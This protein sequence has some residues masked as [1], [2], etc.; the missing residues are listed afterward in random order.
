MESSSQNSNNILHSRFGRSNIFR[1]SVGD[2]RICNDKNLRLEIDMYIVSLAVADF[3]L[4]FLMLPLAIVRQHVGYWPFQSNILCQYF[5]SGN[6]L[7]CLASVLSLCCISIDRYIAVTR[8][9]QYNRTRGCHRPF[10]MLLG[11]WLLA[12]TSVALPYI[13]SYQ[14]HFSEGVCYLNYNTS[15]RL[16]VAVF[17]WFIPIL[18]IV[19]VYSKIYSAIRRHSL[20]CRQVFKVPTINVH[21]DHSRNVQRQPS[22]TI[23]TSYSNSS[24]KPLV[25][26][27]YSLG[28]LGIPMF[29]KS[30][31][32]RFKIFCRMSTNDEV[33]DSID[34]LLKYPVKNKYST[35]VFVHMHPPVVNK[36][37]QEIKQMDYDLKTSDPVEQD[38]G[39]KLTLPNHRENEDIKEKPF[40]NKTARIEVVMY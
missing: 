28:N 8:P 17:L 39:E 38:Q 13:F 16:Y 15:F 29:T 18:I 25:L 10:S 2:S 40:P 9:L 24:R 12:F 35:Q 7:F 23:M 20:R 19:C 31:I 3:L 30:L 1:K 22:D 21:Q 32:V 33:N 27:R 14:H 11:T 36:T 6:L 4:S 34:G 26:A 5:M 37:K